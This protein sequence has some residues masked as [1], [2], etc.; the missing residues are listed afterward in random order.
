M[1][2]LVPYMWFNLVSQLVTFDKNLM[3]ASLIYF[4]HAFNVFLFG[5]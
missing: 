5:G 4:L 1:V 3:R 2:H